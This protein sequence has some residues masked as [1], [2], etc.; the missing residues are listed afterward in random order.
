MRRKRYR[1]VDHVDD[2]TKNNVARGAAPGGERTL[3]FWLPCNRHS[4]NNFCS[5]PVH[6][7]TMSIASR[8]S[9]V[10]QK[11]NIDQKPIVL[12]YI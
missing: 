3:N 5:A 10:Y 11:K 4:T 9:L 6:Q 12:V 8:V 1:E 2:P 7:S